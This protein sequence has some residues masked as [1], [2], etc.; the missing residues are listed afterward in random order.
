MVIYIDVLITVNLIIDY[1]LVLLTAKINKITY[2]NFRIV[3]G[4]LI[5][6]LFSIYIFYENAN[7]LINAFVRLFSAAVVI[8]VA[9]GFNSIK[10]YFRN[11]ITLFIVSFIYCGAMFAIWIIFKT[12]SIV[13]NNSVVYL[14]IS[15]IALISL[16]IIIYFLIIFLK[17]ILKKNA[18]KANR[19]DVSLYFCGKKE[20]FK[21]I[22][23]TG[24][25]VKDILSNSEVIFISKSM[26][27]KFI[28]GRPS[29]FPNMYRLLPCGSVTGSKILEGV[30][31]DKAEISIN[32]NQI[33]L[34]RPIL[35]FCETNIDNEFSLLLNPEILE[36]AE[37]KTYAIKNRK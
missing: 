36:Y 1:F 21:A 10:G 9:F 2:K 11:I 31:I 27:F 32:K 6:S 35:A 22:F 25:S 37:E 13:I 30:R 24:N 33:I 17:S 7:I 3:L 34:T 20:Q 19:A 16:T 18:I 15:P 12:N 5:G 23:D 29:D 8:L 26:G 4:A 14:N 28:G